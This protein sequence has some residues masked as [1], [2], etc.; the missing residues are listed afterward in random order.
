[1]VLLDSRVVTKRYGP[2]LLGGLPRAE[3]VVGSWA[4]VR[5]K[6]EDF[7]A[8]QGIGAVGVIPVR[9]SKIVCVGRNYV[10]HARELGNEVPAGADAVLQAAQ[11][12]RSAPATPSCSRDVS[13][14]VEF[15]AEIGVVIGDA[16]RRRERGGGGARHRRLRLPQRRHLPR[17]AE[18]RRPVGAR[19][20]LR[21]LL[22]G[23]TRA[24]PRGSTGAPSR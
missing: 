15:E 17:P 19:Q 12:P 9:P 18:D 5:T 10:A 7:F 13:R 4:Q 21:H 3:R 22:P 23:W 11:R 16:A 8:R 20:G 14:Q 6:C 2:L 1:M 24:W